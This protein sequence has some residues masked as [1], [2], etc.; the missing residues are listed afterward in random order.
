M[1]AKDPLTSLA[2][3]V[4]YLSV[5][6]R[7]TFADSIFYDVRSLSAEEQAQLNP[8]NDREGSVVVVP[9]SGKGRLRHYRSAL[10]FMHAE[11]D[12]IRAIAVAGVR[13]SAK[14][15]HEPES[16]QRQQRCSGVLS[17]AGGDVRVT[18]QP[19]GVDR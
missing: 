8:L 9:P 5:K 12:N 2:L 16:G 11:G 17:Q 6:T 13:A 3:D 10:R 15:S 14:S 4:P 19:Q 1:E 18:G 7:N